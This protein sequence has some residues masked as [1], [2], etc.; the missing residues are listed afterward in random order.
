MFLVIGILA[1]ILG[2]VMF[3]PYIRDILKHKTKPERASWLIWSLLGLIAVSSQLAKGATDSIWMTV[4]Q[5]FGT[6]TIFILSFTYGFGGFVKR[7]IFALIAALFGLSLW[8][9][10]RDAVYAL[11]ITILVDAIGA[12]LT[13]IKATEHP[14]SETVITWVLSAIS[15][16][17]GTVAVGYWNP[18]LMIYPFYVFLANSSVLIG[19]YIGYQRKSK[20]KVEVSVK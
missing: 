20:V 11:I 17:L 2:I 7:D 8:L 10:T 13:A 5:T 6:I 1:G 4:A 15:G 16:L 19:I 18:I 9:V 12:A 14:E 3:I